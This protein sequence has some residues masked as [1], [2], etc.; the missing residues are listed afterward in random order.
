VEDEVKNSLYS[1]EDFQHGKAPWIPFC[2]EDGNVFT[3]RWP[4]DAHLFAD[5]LVNRLS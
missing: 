1:A 4:L 5:T 2:L 3:S